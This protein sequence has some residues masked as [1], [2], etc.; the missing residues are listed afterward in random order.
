MSGITEGLRRYLSEAELSALGTAVV[1][2]AGAGGL[3]SN[4][5]MLLARSG[6]RRF[7]IADFDTV[8]VSNLNR[9]FFWPGDVG[10][11]KV[12][13]LRD[14]L[15]RLCPEVDIRTHAVRLDAGNVCSLFAGCGIVVEAL[16]EA[17][18]KAA[19]CSALLPNG[20]FVTAASGIGGYNRPAMSVR[21]VTASFVC[22]GDFT[23]EVNDT[24]P[25]L[26]PRV[27]QAAAM[28]ADVVLTRI[29]EP[30][31]FAAGKH[32]GWR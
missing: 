30:D 8:D 25:P 4:V 24:L 23:S 10:R 6:V 21:R 22:V 28:Q 14:Q 7:V 11:L 29:L 3:G 26:A 1:G 16:D 27:M 31:A 17:A 13:A 20:F 2:I 19:V 9:Q 15:L 18:S 5:A 12:E 32:E